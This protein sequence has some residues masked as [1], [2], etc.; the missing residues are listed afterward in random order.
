MSHGKFIRVQ[1]DG[2]DKPIEVKVEYIA[3]DCDLAIL[4]VEDPEYFAKRML[5]SLGSFRTERQVSRSVIPRWRANFCDRGVYL[6]SVSE[7][8]CTGVRLHLLVQVDSAIN[9]GNSGGPVMQGDKVIELPSK[10]I[11]A[12]KILDTSFQTP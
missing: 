4:K 2:D 1:K 7:D 10:P 3:H 12:L 11:P 5:L 9:S 8:M 6:G